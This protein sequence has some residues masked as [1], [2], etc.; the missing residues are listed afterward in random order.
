MC[1]LFDECLVI[2]LFFEVVLSFFGFVFY[3]IN[4]VGVSLCVSKL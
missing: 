2:L 3:Y 1:I 4:V